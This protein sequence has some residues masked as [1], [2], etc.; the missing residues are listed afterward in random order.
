[1]VVA[2]PSPFK[3]PDQ[4]LT[5]LPIPAPS[6]FQIFELSPSLDLD[7][8]ELQKKFYELSKV[9]HPDRYAGKSQQET[10]YATRWSTALNRA[11][12]VLRDPV[13]R[14]E[15]VLDLNGFQRPEKTSV[16]LDLAETYFELQDLLLEQGDKKPLQDFRAGLILESEQLEKQWQKLAAEW[17]NPP[18]Q[19]RL[20]KLHEHLNRRKYLSSMLADIEKKL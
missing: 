9:F 13:A 15:Y 17:P 18:G 7:T 3:L 1:V 5:D 14:S 2:R 20:L 10:L 19:E 6:H 11:Y 8:S 12:K 16:P 4:R